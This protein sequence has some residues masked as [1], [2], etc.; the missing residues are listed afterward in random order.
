MRTIRH[1]GGPR[2][3]VMTGLAGDGTFS[4]GPGG[5]SGDGGLT[6]EVVLFVNKVPPGAVP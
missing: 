2:I 6:S 3:D 5:E 4:D 1:D